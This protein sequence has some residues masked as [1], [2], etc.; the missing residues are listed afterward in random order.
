MFTGIIEE[1][2]TVAS[3]RREGNVARLAVR[4]EAVRGDLRIGDSLAV[5]GVCLTVER[6]EPAQLWLSMM[7]E[8][9]RLTT[10]GT[11]TAGAQVN[12]ERAL[13][14]DSRLGGHLVAGHVDGVGT[15]QAARGVG[16]ER[17][18]TISL[19]PELARF[20]APKGSIAVDGI[21][22]TV[23]EVDAGAFSV[24]LIRH[25]MSATTLALRK[26]GD[27]VNLEVDLIARYLDRLVSSS[28]QAGG[29]TLE[30][31]RELGF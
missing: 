5:N 10:L 30:R 2:G 12:L 22:L 7:P 4:A 16:E 20:V 26:T 8:T 23:T 18:L 1:L 11:L 24:S 31:M 19:P 21:S 25:T 15:V 29:L 3:L 9:L 17:V 13:R 14:L 6:I 27:A 28:G